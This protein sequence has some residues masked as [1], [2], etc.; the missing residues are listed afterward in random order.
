MKNPAQIRFNLPG[1]TYTATVYDLSTLQEWIAQNSARI[2][3]AEV[4]DRG[5]FTYQELE[6]LIEQEADA[7]PEDEDIEADIEWA[8]FV[9]G[10][11]THS[12]SR[13]HAFID[14]SD[15]SACGF[16]PKSGHEFCSEA[17]AGT[18]RCKHCER[19]ASRTTF[20]P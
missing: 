1:H 12:Y 9:T 11:H 13:V 16:E 5:G 20:N 18:D 10:Y 6:A 14:G 19:I 15:D 3:D 4:I 8:A 17:D 2:I 7:G